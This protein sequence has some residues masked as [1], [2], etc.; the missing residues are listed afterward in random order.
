LLR[1]RGRKLDGD[2]ANCLRKHRVD[3]A[4]GSHCWN[5]GT[6]FKT[7]DH[8]LTSGH[9]LILTRKSVPRLVSER[10]RWGSRYTRVKLKFSCQLPRCCSEECL[11]FKL[12]LTC[13][14]EISRCKERPTGGYCLQ[15]FRHRISRH[16][17][18]TEVRRSYWTNSE[19]SNYYKKP[20]EEG[21]N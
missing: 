1:R 9:I 19:I 14:F 4:R 3:L 8:D 13:F 5:T 21:K 17:A 10:T 11:V 2:I 15:L 6:T 12:Q 7:F 18:S 16:A 20:A